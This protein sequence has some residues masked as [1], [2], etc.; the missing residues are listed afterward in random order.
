[1]ERERLSKWYW[2][3]GSPVEHAGLLIWWKYIWKCIQ[4]T[5]YTLYTV[6]IRIGRMRMQIKS[7]Y[8]QVAGYVRTSVSLRSSRKKRK[9]VR[10][11]CRRS[12][13]ETMIRRAQIED[14]S[15]VYDCNE[16]Y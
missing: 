6:P 12:V 1:M 16:I 9:V 5:V 10:R 2:G 15:P 3:L 7:E 4:Y 14:H 13:Q 8:C 11:V